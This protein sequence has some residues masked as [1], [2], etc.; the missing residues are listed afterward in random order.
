M[1]I[2][3][4]AATESRNIYIQ[5]AWINVMVLPKACFMPSLPFSE[6]WTI[7]LGVIA[8]AKVTMQ[9]T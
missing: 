7:L 3:C 4:I 8:A 2:K 5:R 1:M 9:G 6:N